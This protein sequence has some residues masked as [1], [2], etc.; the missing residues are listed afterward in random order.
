MRSSSEVRARSST[1]SCQFAINARSGVG[2]T[3]GFDHTGMR[4]TAMPDKSPEATP[5][6]S[7]SSIVEP[8]SMKVLPWNRRERGFAAQW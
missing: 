5:G 7:V 4:L 6:P 3:N 2:K 8:P 1:F